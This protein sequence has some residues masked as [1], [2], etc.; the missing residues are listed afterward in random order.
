MVGT[1]IIN[2]K[3]V[4]Q[5]YPEEWREEINQISVYINDIS[6][7]AINGMEKKAAVTLVS[8]MEHIGF[9]KMSVNLLGSAFER[10]EDLEKVNRVRDENIE[11]KVLNNVGQMLNDE[12]LCFISVPA[13]HGGPIVTKDS[14][15]LYA[16]Y[17]EYEEKSWKKIIEHE[18]FICLEQMFFIEEGGKWKQV[19]DIQSLSCVTAELK[20][21]ASG[22]AVAVLKKR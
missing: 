6:I 22:L 19:T 8:T 11:Y 16:C 7:T 9:D 17:W 15:G 1:D 5:R 4:W 21:C 2:P 18:C 14:K 13:G 20:D 10:A 12:G 3:N